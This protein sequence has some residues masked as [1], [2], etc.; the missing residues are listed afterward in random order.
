MYYLFIFIFIV[1][2]FLYLHIWYQY[3]T[4]DDLEIYSIE[5]PSKSKLEEI[6]NMRQ[7]IVFNYY[8]D[9]ILNNIN[10]VNLTNNC[11][12]FDVKI[13]EKPNNENDEIYLPLTL[14]ETKDLFSKDDTGKYYSENNSDFLNET[15]LI[16]K[17]KYNDEFLRPPLV[18]NCNY[19]FMFGS[20]NSSSPLRYD[21]NFRNYYYVTEGSVKMKLIPPKFT[22]YLHMKKDYMN[23]EFISPIDC[24]DVQ[25]Q[26]K[27][28]YGKIKTM[29]VTLNKG[30]IIY[31][32]AFWWYSI[33]FSDNS[34]IC[35]FKYKTFMNVVATIPQ[36]TM[37]LLQQQNIKIHKTDIID[38]DSNDTV[39]EVKY[40]KKDISKKD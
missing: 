21:L 17:F 5:Q 31:I 38:N 24:W 10:M 6:C 13:R 26:Y 7:P 29:D 19:D 9:E 34:L 30:D 32:P 37:N 20:K 35:C 25:E 28:D 39:N 27:N 36:L 8:S 11:G 14:K 3:K 33:Q 15:V 40:I 22:K 18:F 12:I 23:F 2:L 4:S 1:I 16:K